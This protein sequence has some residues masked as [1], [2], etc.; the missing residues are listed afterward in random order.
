MFT[1]SNLTE[2]TKTARYGSTVKKRAGENT[3]IPD[4]RWILRITFMK[5]ITSSW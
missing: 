3:D 1:S 2:F 5:A 4:L